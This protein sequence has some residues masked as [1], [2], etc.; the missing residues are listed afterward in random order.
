[1]TTSLRIFANVWIALVALTGVAAC[2]GDGGGGD[3][4]GGVGQMALWQTAVL[5]ETSNTGD[6]TKPQ[7]AM[8]AIGNAIAVWQQSDGAR[9][10]IWSN[11]FESGKLVLFH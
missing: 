9:S 1:M 7:I 10:N 5:I 8:D 2:G 3:D 4:G 6:A 11:R